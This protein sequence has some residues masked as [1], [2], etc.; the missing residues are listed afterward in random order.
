MSNGLKTHRGGGQPTAS[1]LASYITQTTGVL[2]VYADGTS[3]SDSND[4]LSAATPKLTLQAVFNLVPYLVK[5]N[6]CV[7]LSG[8]FDAQGYPYLQR[9]VYPGVVLLVDGGSALTTFADNG[10]SPWSADISSTGTIGLTTAGWTPDA[11]K[12]Y[13]VE[14]LTGAAAGQ[15][16]M[17]QGNTATTITVT[18]TWTTEPGAGATFRISR[19]TTTL[20]SSTSA[21]SPVFSNL[22]AAGTLHLQNIYISGTKCYLT[23]TGSAVNGVSLSSIISVGTNTF[24]FA[25]SAASFLVYGWGYNSSTFAWNTANTYSRVGIS[26]IGVSTNGVQLSG[27][28]G[29]VNLQHSVI[30][31]LRAIYGQLLSISGGSRIEAM[32]NYYIGDA[33]SAPTIATSTGCA[34]TRFGSILFADSTSRIGSGVDISGSAS[35]A[36]ECNHSRLHLDG[37]V[38]GTG[39]TGAGVYAHNGSVVNIKNGAPPTL[40][41]TVGDLSFDGTTEECEWTDIDAGNK[42]TDLTEATVAKEVA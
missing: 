15:H 17:I 13:I 4:G 25:A 28:Q 41:G 7:H 24:Q 12:G 18:K 36:I 26:Q 35:H 10:G 30:R 11:Y 40:T 22:L 19:P 9:A 14:V 33:D 21:F 6:V 38:T 42:H 32:Q 1:Q 39:N 3:G 2:H 29:Y 23:I 8:T 5:H 31:N 27:W 37:A 16:R 34:A 20:S